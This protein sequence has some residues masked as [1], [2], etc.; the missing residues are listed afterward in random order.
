MKKQTADLSKIEGVLV[1]KSIFS[2]TKYVCV[3]KYKIRIFRGGAGRGAGGGSFTSPT[4][5]RT[6][7]KPTRLG[8]NEI[9]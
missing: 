2:E 3:L 7:E 6:P 9:R 1:L 5:K 8:L 4:A